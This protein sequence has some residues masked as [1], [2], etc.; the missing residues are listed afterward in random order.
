MT[1][2]VTP[3]LD[4]NSS[5]LSFLNESCPSDFQPNPHATIKLL[6]GKQ[7]LE[8]QFEA[9][10]PGKGLARTTSSLESRPEMYSL[11]LRIMMGRTTGNSRANPALMQE[12][13]I[14][15]ALL[16]RGATPVRPLFTCT[17]TD[18]QLARLCPISSMVGARWQV[19]RKASL[20]PTWMQLREHHLTWLYDPVRQLD[21][22]YWLTAAQSEQLQ[23]IAPAHSSV[24]AEHWDSILGE[25]TPSIRR[26]GYG[27]VRDI[28]PP[29]LL[30]SVQEY[31]RELIANGFLPLGDGQ[32]LRF[33]L[34]NEPLA[35][36]LH[37]HTVPLISR[38][39]PEPIK[40]SYTYLGFYLG[41][42]VLEKHTDREQCEY[43]LSLTINATPSAAAADAWPLYAD[44]KN[45]T[46]V[47]ALLGAGD[48]LIFKGRELPHYRHRLDENRTSSSIFFHY[49]PKDFAGT[50]R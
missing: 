12:L 44:L 35:L 13:I 20:L 49:V 31:Y 40:P 50:L 14:A 21:W 18:D 29:E 25:A 23:E 17:L 34:H 8:F 9:P 48:G 10:I 27:I 41:G 46:T 37:Q 1:A 16:P 5:V 32:S 43:T 6:S 33:T 36:W 19:P 7:G 39:I 28:L 2:T 3:N 45:G 4:L 47:E 30:R 42:A 15:G 26:S 22:P 38:I 24:D 11:L